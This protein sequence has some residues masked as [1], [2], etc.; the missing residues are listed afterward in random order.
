MARMGRREVQ[1]QIILYRSQIQCHYSPWIPRTKSGVNSG[2]PRRCRSRTASRRCAY[3]PVAYFLGT[4]LALRATL[5]PHGQHGI[6]N[7]QT[8]RSP[9]AEGAVDMVL[10]TSSTAG[11]SEHL[12]SCPASSTPFVH[13]LPLLLFCS[14]AFSPSSFRSQS[15]IPEPSSSPSRPPLSCVTP[16]SPFLTSPPLCPFISCL[17]L[18]FSTPPCT[19]ASRTLRPLALDTQGERLGCGRGCRAAQGGGYPRIFEAGA[20]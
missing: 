16:S 13:S 7:T 5:S 11:A 1:V 19:F 15:Q 6:D 8:S 2:P 20:V 18:C 9:T 14:F 3:P 12:I 4:T 10:P 17:L